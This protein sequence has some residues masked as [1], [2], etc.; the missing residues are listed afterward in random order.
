[1]IR[2]CLKKITLVIGLVIVAFGGSSHRTLVQPYTE[3]TCASDLKRGLL[4]YYPFNGN[5][6]DA[7]GNGNQ[8]FPRNGA[9]LTTDQNGEALNAAGFDGEDDYIIVPGNSR[10]N[11]DSF[12]ISF[13]VLVN[14]ITRRN[15]T[16]NRVRFSDCSSLVFGVGESLPTDYDWSFGVTPGNDGC[17]IIYGYDPSIAMHAKR[18]IKQRVWHNVIATFGKG[19]QRI[20]VDGVQQGS[21]SRRFQNAKKCADADLVIGGWWAKDIISIDGKIDE[22]RLY[23][24]VINECEIAK[25]ATM[26]MP[27][28]RRTHRLAMR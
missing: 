16:V 21:S 3:P 23:G 7:S 25:L 12:T 1:M 6:N 19:M 20:Y 2:V 22:V 24:R 11:T 26:V 8:A 17:S 9:H 4:A 27:D 5:F 28:T 10:L 18:I 14:D 13:I 15:T